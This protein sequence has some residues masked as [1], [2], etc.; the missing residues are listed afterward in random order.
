[1]SVGLRSR[2]N[3]RFARLADKPSLYKLHNCFDK[4]K[5]DGVAV[6]LIPGIDMNHSQGLHRMSP[7]HPR[8]PNHPSRQTLEANILTLQET[9]FVSHDDGAFS[10]CCSGGFPSRYG[11]IVL[12][13]KS[14][15][16]PG[17][18][19]DEKESDASSERPGATAFG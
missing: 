4:R 14:G 18:G 5:V 19:S 15:G 1:M 11:T 12:S 7:D 10:R 16:H 8:G 9:S 17:L 2:L 13:I 6:R 3:D